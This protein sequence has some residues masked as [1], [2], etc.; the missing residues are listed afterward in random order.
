MAKKKIS[1]KEL[2]DLAERI[3][4]EEDEKLLVENQLKKALADYANLERDLDKRL[5][6]RGDQMKSQIAR[7]LMD[8]LDDI[9]LAVES[10]N[11]LEMTEEVKA[12]VEGVK[13]TLS[14]I[15]KAVGEFGIENMGVKSGDDFDSSIHEAIGTVSEGEK[16]KVH[17]VVQPGFMLGEMVIRPARVIVSQGE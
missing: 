9:N 8:V 4:K 1:E 5:G 11:K 12:W 7:T 14:H 16:G 17:Q 2:K 3:D 10:G 15:E 13:A 6:M